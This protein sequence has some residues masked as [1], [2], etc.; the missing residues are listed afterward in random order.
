MMAEGKLSVNP[1]NSWS[2]PGTVAA[3]GDRGSHR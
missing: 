1:V 2:W 3:V